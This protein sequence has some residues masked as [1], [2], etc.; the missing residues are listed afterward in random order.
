[1]AT[2]EL[3]RPAAGDQP[4]R[5][6]AAPPRPR[7]LAAG[8]VL[9]VGAVALLLAALLNSSSLLA[10]AQ[11]Q[12]DGSRVRGAALAVAEPF[13]DVADAVGLT[14]PRELLD[15]WLGRDTGSQNPNDDGVV[16]AGP[17]TT[18]PVAATAAPG[19]STAA[20]PAPP[21]TGAPAAPATSTPVPSTP[22]AAAGSS[23]PPLPAGTLRVLIAGDSMSQGV[24]QMLA[25]LAEDG[26]VYDTES[27]GK[28]STGLT[29]PDF[30]DWPAR[31]VQATASY[32]PQ[33]VVLMY[34]GNDGQPIQHADGTYSQVSEPGWSE[35]Y[36]ARVGG[37]MDQLGQE[38]RRV[39][40]VGTPNSSSANFNKRLT[41]I[42]QVLST[43][44]ATR[45]WVTYVDAWKLFAPNGT[46]TSSLTDTDG[47]VKKMRN[48]K[49]GYHLTIDGYKYLAKAVFADLEQ[50]RAA[51]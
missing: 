35:E 5:G 51:G 26:A 24:G 6:P 14:K 36:G 20:S 42:N 21:T 48:T 9:V 32:D 43:Q 3:E 19:T 39:V 1:M 18:A 45:P 2:Q 15:G 28:P 29:R 44:A 16:V 34:G 31:L 49:D 47:R 25:P 17:G 22:A 33:I 8:R 50:V 38:G 41:V 30:F 46:F 4:Q 10:L 13:H 37:V 7:S 11:G 40:W 23:Q 27:I 12:P